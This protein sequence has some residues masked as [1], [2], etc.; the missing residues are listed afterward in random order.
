MSICLQIYGQLTPT[1]LSPT[2][3]T[4]LQRELYSI[5][6][7]GTQLLICVCVYAYVCIGDGASVVCAE[8]E[9]SMGCSPPSLSVCSFEV[10]S[11]L[12]PASLLSQ[13]LTSTP[14]LL[15]PLHTPELLG[16]QRLVLGCQ[17]CMFTCAGINS[18]PLCLGSQLFSPLSSLGKAIHAQCYFL[19]LKIKVELRHSERDQGQQR[20]RAEFSDINKRNVESLKHQ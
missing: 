16:C 14:I 3:K 9:D 17:T 1:P 4:E 5:K 7:Q 6:R 13:K 2:T 19:S 20:L 18:A 15:C 10:G 12:R 11:L 8:A